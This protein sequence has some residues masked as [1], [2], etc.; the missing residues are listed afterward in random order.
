M[1]C[2]GLII[3]IAVS[4][5]PVTTADQ[6]D[7]SSSAR[8]VA[9]AGPKRGSSPVMRVEQCQGFDNE[10]IIVGHS[11]ACTSD[12]GE[13]VTENGHARMWDVL[14]DTT[15]TRVRFGVDS[16]SDARGLGRACPVE[17]RLY[18]APDF[19]QFAT[20]ALLASA[21]VDVPDGAAATVMSVDFDDVPV[22]GGT[23]LVVELYNGD[24]F[25]GNWAF[26]PGANAGG[27]LRPSYIRA[28][29]CGP[30]DWTD[31]SVLG[32]REQHNVLCWDDEPNQVELFCR[33]LV[34]KNTKAKGGCGV[35]PR[36]NQLYLSA[37]TCEAVEDCPKKLNAKRL[38]C[39]DG[40][41]GFCKKLKAVRE[42]CVE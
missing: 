1:S 25:R 42:A 39:P 35:C 19:P 9:E 24:G 27:Q 14:G 13:S 22:P 16:C 28:A 29:P 41:E 34:K 3:S 4:F 10:T 8:A 15:V 11:V 18:S 5:T 2:L 30:S 38:D 17:I 37:E 6:P 31:L 32:Y 23:K 33:F 21:N 26:W 20:A 36:R 7:W 40:G 12:R